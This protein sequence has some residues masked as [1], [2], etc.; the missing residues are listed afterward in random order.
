MPVVNLE[1]RCCENPAGLL[2][3]G[4]WLEA[5]DVDQVIADFRAAGFDAGAIRNESGRL[6]LLI[7]AAPPG[8]RLRTVASGSTRSDMDSA[9]TSTGCSLFLVE[10]YLG[11]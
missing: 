10:R 2:M 11:P 6:S 5:D 7:M 4:L 3:V 8:L 9:P 1:I